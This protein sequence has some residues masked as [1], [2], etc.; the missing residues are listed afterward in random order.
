MSEYA[1]GVK[2]VPFDGTKENFYLWTTQ[3]LH[4]AKT[5]N[6]QLETLGSV[7]VPKE[8]DVLDETKEAETV[9]PCVSTVYH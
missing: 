3:L 9:L 6:C 8:T 1:K 5:F 7:A 4:F 2:K